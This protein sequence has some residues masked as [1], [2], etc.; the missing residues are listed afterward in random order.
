MPLFTRKIDVYLFAKKRSFEFTV[1]RGDSINIQVTVRDLR[2][3]VIPLTD[4]KIRAEFFDNC[5]Q[6]IELANTSSGGSDSQIEIT[7]VNNG[8]FVIKVAKDLTTR[9]RLDSFVECEIE[10]TN[11][12][13]IFTII[14][15]NIKFT[16]EQIDWETP[17]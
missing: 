16:P 8:V 9:F 4:Y 15:D 7:D 1:C 11:N 6:G 17:T 2:G 5:G 3:T 12:N 13:N 14:K 10:D